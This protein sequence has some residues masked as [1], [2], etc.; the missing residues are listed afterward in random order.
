VVERERPVDAAIAAAGVR[1]GEAAQA[2]W[3]EEGRRCCGAA[4][5]RCCCGAARHDPRPTSEMARGGSV[6]L[7]GHVA[8]LL[9]CSGVVA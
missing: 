6:L 7:Q 1:E 5:R 9:R 8:A 3:L 2:R 4:S